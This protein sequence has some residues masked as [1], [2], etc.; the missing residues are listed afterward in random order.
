MA[1]TSQG[2]E[3]KR[4]QDIIDSRIASARNLFGN[5]AGVSSNDVLG[6]A[7]RVHADSERDLYELAES[8]YNSFNPSIATGVSLS[9]LVAYAGLTRQ[10]AAPSTVTLKVSGDYRVSIPSESF[11][12]S[13]LTSNRF[14]TTESV[15]LN[16]D[17]ISGTVIDVI[18]AQDTAGYTLTLGSATFTYTSG[19]GETR[20]EI[21][22]SLQGIINASNDFTAT[23]EDT[24]RINVVF[25]DEFVSRNSTVT[26]N[27]SY[28]KITKLV[29]AQSEE[30]GEISQE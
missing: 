29:S 12:D 4:L 2:L 16:S 27:I 17:N 14:Q 26:A 11:V 20:G 6:R 22:T 1:L 18:T 21:A 25:N 19:T 3:V 8:V 9:R 23:V 24:S 7:L 10:E 5:G 30:V 13:S 28:R 15:T